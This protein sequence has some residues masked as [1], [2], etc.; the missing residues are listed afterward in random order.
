MG[1]LMDTK[2]TIGQVI[3]ILS[4]ILGAVVLGYLILILSR[5]AV[6]IRNINNILEA[7]KDNIDNTMNSIPG[8]VENVNE[9]TGSV[10]KKTDMLD[11]LFGEKEEAEGSS[12]ISNLET[13]I[14][15]AATVFEIFNEIK[16]FFGNKKKR[17]FKIKR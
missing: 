7:N 17:I 15:S 4:M 3:I 2:F 6:T 9:I 1:D 10:R 8:I 16:T 11:G 14:S 13:V 5:V 12:I